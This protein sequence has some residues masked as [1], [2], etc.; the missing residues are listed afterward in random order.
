M[1]NYVSKSVD[2]LRPSGIRRYFDIAATMDNVVTLG[3]G[4]PNFVTPEHIVDKSVESLRLGQT[5]YTSNSG[6]I[7]LRQAIS[8]Y[9]QRLYGLYYDPKDQVL[10]TVGVSEGLFLALKAILDPGDEVLVV[11]P[12][13]VAN[14]AAVEM[15]GGVPVRVDTCVEHEFQVTGAALEAAV[16]PRT[17]AILV[18]YPNNP[19]GAVLSRERLL[20]IAA[21]AQKHDLLVISDEIYERLVYGIEHICFATLPGMYDRTIL[22]SG[23]SKSFAM[24]G[25]RIGYVTAPCALME[26]MRKLHQ[27]LIMSAPT[28]GQTAAIEALLHGEDDVRAM[29]AA[30]DR[31]RRLLVGGLNALGLTCFEPRGAFYTFPSVAATGMTDEAFCDTLLQEE[32]VAVI[33]GSAFGNSGTGFVR[34]SYTNSDENI[35]I[36]LERMQRF[37]R[38]HG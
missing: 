3:I 5:A 26:A 19:T 27:Y 37:M 33:P 36:A 9:I 38:R 32:G 11:E 15:A 29:C 24:T 18:S 8:A 7:E 34:A 10:V 21:V 4:E 22:L 35:E 25:W 23:V 16:T 30:Y 1:R 14:T 6:M 12:C 31:R 2:N 20:E 28:M 17:K 13:F